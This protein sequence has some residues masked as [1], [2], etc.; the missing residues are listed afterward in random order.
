MEKFYAVEQE[1]ENIDF[2]QTKLQEGEYEAC[3]FKNCNFSAVDFFKN[4]FI[5]TS[6][7]NCDL[8]N[9]SVATTSL[10][11]VEFIGCKLLG[12][13]F[14][15]CRTFGLAMT[16][17]QCQLNH[18]SFYQLDLQNS[19]FQN[20]ELKSVDF[21][22]ANLAKVQLTSCNLLHANFEQTNLEGADLRHSIQYSIDP[23]KNRLRGATFSLQEVVGLLDQHKINIDGL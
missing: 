3:T 22:E 8:S 2:T 10:Q 9:A 1:F 13:A 19:R 5:E 23:N 11:E 21:A 16:F 17:E 14:E 12:I 18:A 6:F 4:R 20:C 7:V 15:H